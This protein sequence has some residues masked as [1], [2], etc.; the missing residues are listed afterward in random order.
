MWHQI[1]FY[2]PTFRNKYLAFDSADQKRLIGIKDLDMAER[3]LITGDDKNYTIMPEQLVGLDDML[4]IIASY[5]KGEQGDRDITR[6]N[7]EIV[8]RLEPSLSKECPHLVVACGVVMAIGKKQYN[9][10]ITIL[11]LPDDVFRCSTSYELE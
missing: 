3:M 4:K 2:E 9:Q 6:E 1:F 11:D 7:R 10:A 8:Y 5:P